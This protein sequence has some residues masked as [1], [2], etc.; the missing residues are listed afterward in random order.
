MLDSFNLN[1]SLWDIVSRPAGIFYLIL[2]QTVEE[3]ELWA[4]IKA[5]D[6]RRSYRTIKAMI[7]KQQSPLI[8]IDITLDS[9]HVPISTTCTAKHDVEMHLIQ[10]NQHHS[11]QAL[12]TSLMRSSASVDVIDPM[13]QSNRIDDLLHGTFYPSSISDYNLTKLNRIGSNLLSTL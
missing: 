6:A 9:G 5:K 12:N 3:K 8:D 10:R 11:K 2:E 1:I 13:L 4:I 7:G